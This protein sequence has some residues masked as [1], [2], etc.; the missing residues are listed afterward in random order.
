MCMLIIISIMNS[1]DDN[2]HDKTTCLKRLRANFTSK[3]CLCRHIR[4]G[5]SLPVY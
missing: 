3:F 2:R 5:I 4:N 1:N